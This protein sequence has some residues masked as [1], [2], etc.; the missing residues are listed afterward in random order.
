MRIALPGLMAAMLAVGGQA[1][2]APQISGTGE[3]VDRSAMPGAVVFQEHCASCHEH[4]VAKAPSTFLLTMMEPD[5][6]L[7]AV[8]A[9]IMQSQ[10]GKLTPEEKIQVAEYLFGRSISDQKAPAEPPQCTGEAAKF[11]LS[12]PPGIHGWGF[13]MQNARH[14]S[15]DVAKLPL[16]DIPKLKLKWALA[17]PGAIRARSQPTFAMGALF[18]GSQKGIVYALDAK[19]GCVRWTYRATAEVRTPVV[20]MP[21]SEGKASYSPLAFFGDL[22]GRVYAVDALTGQ[23]QWVIKADDH[24]ATTITG[25]PVYYKDRLYVPVS[26]LEETSAT[27]PT[28]PCC[29]FRGSVIALEPR[30]GK[31]LWHSYAIPTAPKQVGVTKAGTSIMVPSGAPIWSALSIDAK[32]GLVYATTGN[33]YTPPADTYSDGVL[34]FDLVTGAMRWH[35]QSVPDDVWNVACVM[36]SGN[37]NCPEDTGPDYDIGAGSILA[38]RRWGGDLLLIGRKDGTV[39][40]FDVQ[41]RVLRWERKVGRGSIQGGVQ[42]GMSADSGRLYV[43]IADPA[44]ATDGKVYTEPARPGLYAL[45]ISS[46]ESIWSTPAEDRCNGVRGCDPGILAAVTSIPGAVFAGHMDGRIRAYDA[47]N[48]R[49]IWEYD[50]LGEVVTLSGARAH[51]GSVGGAGP[52]VHDGIVYVNSGYGFANH[53]PGNVLLAFSVDG[54]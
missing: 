46:G 19:S 53:L 11:D 12:R 20:I 6:V 40:A 32:R 10:A 36:E 21:R 45:D 51:G 39:F 26:S 25:S 34:A 44:D 5:A 13:G 8:T 15:A 47:S 52:V 17:Y 14:I 28:Y 33:N 18:V 22:M 3:V 35:W 23:L 27:D 1:T 16:A 41:R 38:T 7:A 30:S 31:V 48:G 49:V 2:A 54:R 29:T 42:W 37:D 50:S 43:P 9:G 24:P 4:S